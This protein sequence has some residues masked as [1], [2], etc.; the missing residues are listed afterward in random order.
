QQRQPRVDFHRRPQAGNPTADNE[1][2][3]K[4]VRDPLGMKR[5]EIAWR[6]ENH[7]REYTAASPAINRLRASRPDWES[8]LSGG[9]VH[10][11]A[12][13]SATNRAGWRLHGCRCGPPGRTRSGN[14]TRET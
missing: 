11:P 13:A 3:D 8:L 12:I 14:R 10:I 9:E 7:A 6:R 1:H 5:H 4:M 2:V